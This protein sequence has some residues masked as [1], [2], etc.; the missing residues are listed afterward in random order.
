[1]TKE[2]VLA[3]SL[4]AKQKEQ[5]ER[6]FK[7]WQRTKAPNAFEPLQ[8]QT[9]VKKM[10]DD[11]LKKYETSQAKKAAKPKSKNARDI[12]RLALE[13]CKGKNKKLT[14]NELY[15]IVN[16]AVEAKERKAIE[17]ERAELK[18]KLAALDAKEVELDERLAEKG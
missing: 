7:A 14:F 2:E 16:D 6:C 5:V 4:T 10:I 3:L 1:M 11:Y 8:S 15:T 13:L 12:Q 9:Q 18:K 17:Q